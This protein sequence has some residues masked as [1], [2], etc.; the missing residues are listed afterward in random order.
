MRTCE[1]ISYN[2]IYPTI[3][4][5]KI[6]EHP[7]CATNRTKAKKKCEWINYLCKDREEKEVFEEQKTKKKKT[8]MELNGM[9]WQSGWELWVKLRKN[10]VK[11]VNRS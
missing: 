10:Y 7:K 2:Y 5:K 3:V 1:W 9:E 6:E 8:K 11:V 4:K